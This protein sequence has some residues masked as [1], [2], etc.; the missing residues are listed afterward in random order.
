MVTICT[1]GVGIAQSVQRLATGWTTEGSDFE[2][3]YGQEFSLLSV[4]Q[5][6]SGARPASY[7]MG[8]GGYF[9]W[10]KTARA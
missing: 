9:H 8:T 2:S 1:N 3:R 10:G 5:T 4:V 6:G 7:A